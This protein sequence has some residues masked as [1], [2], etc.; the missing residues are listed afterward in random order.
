MF[1][2]VQY[3][4]V[5]CHAR[6]AAYSANAP[7]CIINHH[8]LEQS[9]FAPA[10]CRSAVTLVL[11]FKLVCAGPAPRACA[12]LTCV[13]PLPPIARVPLLLLPAYRTAYCSRAGIRAPVAAPQI[14]VVLRERAGSGGQY[15]AR[16]PPCTPMRLSVSDRPNMTRRH[17]S[18]VLESKQDSM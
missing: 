17:N 9:V 18:A 8:T 14:F 11:A 2:G 3:T 7:C 13:L 10:A 6:R 16:S 5:Q 15:T 4:R 1:F 12:S